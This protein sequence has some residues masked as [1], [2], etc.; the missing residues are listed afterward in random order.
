MGAT[1]TRLKT[2]SPVD[3]GIPVE[4][5]RR[6]DTFVLKWRF[7]F[8]PFLFE[9]VFFRRLCVS[10]SVFPQSDLD[11]NELG[12]DVLTAPNYEKIEGWRLRAMKPGLVYRWKMECAGRNCEHFEYV[13]LRWFSDW[14]GFRRS[15]ATAT[16]M[17]S[18]QIDASQ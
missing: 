14:T 4:R 13:R 5:K 3:L 1:R 2:S 16:Y 17:T 8:R 7:D 6:Y 18:F 15:F 12:N 9:E 11:E 10:P